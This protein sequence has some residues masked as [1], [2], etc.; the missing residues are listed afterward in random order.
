MHELNKE[1]KVPVW[2]SRGGW[3]KHRTITL[4]TSVCD[5]SVLIH[6]KEKFSFLYIKPNLRV[7]WIIYNG[8]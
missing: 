4:E 7:I 1:Q 5:K 3:I 6:L 2:R 8:K